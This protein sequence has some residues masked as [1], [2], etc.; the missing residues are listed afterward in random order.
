MNSNSELKLFS[1]SITSTIENL[2]KNYVALSDPNPI[3][4]PTVI[5]GN[6]SSYGHHF[7]IGEPIN[8][9]LGSEKNRRIVT[10]IG[11]YTTIGNNFQI[12][13]DQA[14]IEPVKSISNFNFDSDKESSDTRLI[15]TTIGNDVKIGNNV[16]IK[17]EV[18]IGDGCVINDDCTIWEDVEPYTLVSYNYM[19]SDDNIEKPFYTSDQVQKLLKIA[20][21]NWSDDKV[22]ENVKYLTSDNIN[23]FIERFYV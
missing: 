6:H 12:F 7:S 3:Y 9:N 11:N 21:W 17:A 8:F 1:P 23:E 13:A 15:E 22:K 10:N 18:K 16:R 2:P 20:W 19:N 4:S 14:K 5:I